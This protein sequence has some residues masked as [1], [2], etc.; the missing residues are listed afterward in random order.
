MVNLPLFHYRLARFVQNIVVN[1][2][3]LGTLLCF[4]EMATRE[5]F[6][7]PNNVAKF[8]VISFTNAYFQGIGVCSFTCLTKNVL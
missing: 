4:V 6:A 2:R 3:S 1:L 7:R 5:A 8:G